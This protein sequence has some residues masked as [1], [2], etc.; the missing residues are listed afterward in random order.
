MNIQMNIYGSIIESL[1]RF[2]ENLDLY[3]LAQELGFEYI[4]NPDTG[5]LHH[6]NS[7][8]FF[9]SHNL[10]SANIGNFIGL[11]NL[12]TIPAHLL[13]DG[14]LLPVYDMYTGNLIGRYSL[15]KCK[16]CFQS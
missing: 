2:N 9:G 12:G 8:S 7:D 14:T 3:N 10:H 6:V 16:H 13:K 5:E 4:L 11:V 1:K 15:N